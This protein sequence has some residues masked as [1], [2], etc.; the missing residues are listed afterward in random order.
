VIAL[1]ALF[2]VLG[3][4]AYAVTVAPRNSV[5]SRSIRNLNVKRPDIAPG[6][7]TDD[8]LSSVYQFG[9]G[10]TDAAAATGIPNSTTL[11]GAYQFGFGT[12]DLKCDSTPSFVYRND[13]GNVD[14]DVWADVGGVQSHYLVSPPS[15]SQEVDF[16]ANPSGTADLHVF[17]DS[18]IQAKASAFWTGTDCTVAISASEQF[19]SLGKSKAA[20]HA[21]ALRRL[22]AGGHEIGKK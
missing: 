12:L 13:N 7:V 19:A 15:G 6:A 20:L 2:I 10:Y 8:K 5:T 14:A 3:G 18:V 16:G 1:L 17:G 9:A 21:A 22:K 4:G 11:S